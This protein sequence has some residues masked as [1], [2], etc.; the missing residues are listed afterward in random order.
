MTQLLR[1]AYGRFDKRLPIGPVTWPFHDLL[2]IHAGQVRIDFGTGQ[3]VALSAPDGIL[4]LPDTPFSGIAVGSAAT[5]SVC[6]FQ[7][8]QPTSPGHLR[9]APTDRIDLQSLVRMA[10]RLAEDSPNDT[11]RRIRLL[12]TILDGFAPQF[13]P[14]P[15]DRDARRL[16]RAWELAA[17][18]LWAMRSLVD[19]AALIDLRESGFR[20]LHRNL[21]GTPA[22]AHLRALRLSRAEALLATTGLTLPQIAVSVGYGHAETLNAAFRHSR[23]MTPGAFRRHAK[24]F[25]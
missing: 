15:K 1:H 7:T 11:E 20:T 21:H 14:Q 22:G 3:S 10:L 13:S 6:H 24:P 17:Q 12:H 8:S 18:S 16:S 9:A 2:W 4:I 19:V 25:A 5:A 23:G